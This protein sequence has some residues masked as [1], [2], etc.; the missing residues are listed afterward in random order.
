MKKPSRSLSLSKETLYTVDQGA[1]VAAKGGT[2]PLSLT[3]APPVAALT[4]TIYTHF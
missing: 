1:L 2:L 4:F 3:L